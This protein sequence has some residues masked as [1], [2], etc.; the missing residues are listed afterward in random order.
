MTTELFEHYVRIIGDNLQA[1]ASLYDLEELPGNVIRC[2]IPESVEDKISATRYLIDD[3]RHQL[4]V[5][6][7]TER[8]AIR[9]MNYE[10][11]ATTRY[12]RDLEARKRK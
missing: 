8:V 2:D 11:L 6:D 10:W 4:E 9:L 3:Y 1:I 12:F 7:M 5:G